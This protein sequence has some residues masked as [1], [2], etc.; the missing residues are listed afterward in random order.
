MKPVMYSTR[1]TFTTPSLPNNKRHSYNLPIP[2]F[3]IFDYV[4]EG[5][6]LCVN[7]W[8]LST[9]WVQGIRLFRNIACL[10]D[11][12]WFSHQRERIAILNIL[13][14]W[15]YFNLNNT[16]PF[17]CCEPCRLQTPRSYRNS[18]FN[19]CSSVCCLRTLRVEFL[20]ADQKSRESLNFLSNFTLKTKP[21]Q[22]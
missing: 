3:P 17:S 9:L 6:I 4:P 18:L 7:G 22:K 12:K 8:S 10:M 11:F 1:A 2:C 19:L 15:K 20:V 16:C 5:E 21:Q 13:W 14:F